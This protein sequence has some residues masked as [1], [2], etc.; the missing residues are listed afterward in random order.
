MEVE[1]AAKVEAGV[2]VEAG[3]DKVVKDDTED[4]AAAVLESAAIVSARIVAQQCRISRVLH[5][6]VS[7]ALNAV[8]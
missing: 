6:I 8:S 5:A 1:I 4:R 2:K 3:G 7:N